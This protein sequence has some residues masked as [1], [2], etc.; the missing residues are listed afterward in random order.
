MA[1]FLDSYQ[2]VYEKYSKFKSNNEEQF[3]TLLNEKAAECGIS[4]GIFCLLVE[5]WNI[6]RELG[7]SDIY[8]EAFKEDL[9]SAYKQFQLNFYKP[10]KEESTL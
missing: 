6:S 3:V 8:E 2:I 7:K 9:L 1:F 4:L 10:E 5:K